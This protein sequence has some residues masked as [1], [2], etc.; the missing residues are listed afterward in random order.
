[1]AWRAVRAPF[2]FMG[3]LLHDLFG[4]E[5]EGGERLSRDLNTDAHE[6]PHLQEKQATI[7]PSLLGH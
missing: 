3:T 4:V 6:A 2:S 5:D 7:I 1:M